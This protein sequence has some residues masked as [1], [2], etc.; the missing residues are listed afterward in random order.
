MRLGAQDQSEGPEVV[1]S[2]L[3]EPV[4]GDGEVGRSNVQRLV[5]GLPKQLVERVGQAVLLVVDD[6]GEGHGGP[7]R[8]VG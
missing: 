3:Y 7:R 1:K 4:A 2:F 8:G 6:E 5:I